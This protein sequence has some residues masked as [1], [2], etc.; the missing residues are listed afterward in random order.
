MR[1]LAEKLLATLGTE[2][3]IFAY[4]GFEKRVISDLAEIFPDLDGPLM[5]LTQRIVDL[6]PIARAHYYHPAMKGSWS[7]KAVL[8]TIAPELAYE[9]LGEVQEGGGAQA[10]FLEAVDVS[11]SAERRRELS[12][13]LHQY[14]NRDTLAM[15]QLVHHFLA[16]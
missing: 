8:P 14:C 7:I 2:G 16:S 10:A 9:N 13:A 15:V 4:S 1:P 3:P 5:Q 6:L 12:E 11:T